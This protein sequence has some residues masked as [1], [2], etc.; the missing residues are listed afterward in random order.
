MVDRYLGFELITTGHLLKRA[1]DRADDEVKKRVLGDENDLICSDLSIIKFLTEHDE[2]EI[3]QKD[4]EQYFSL[5]APSVS[6]KLRTLQ[7]EGLINR[8]Y[9]EID[10]RLKRVILTDTAREIDK[11]MR[12][13]LESFEKRIEDVLTD[14]EKEMVFRIS[15]KIKNEFE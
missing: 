2:R 13:E 15:E 10:T 12:N 11:R 9:S 7:K 8:V 5:T 6:N 3:Y 1:K 4:I 14:E